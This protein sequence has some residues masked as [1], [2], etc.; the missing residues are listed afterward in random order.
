MDSSE[1]LAKHFFIADHPGDFSLVSSQDQGAQASISRLSRENEQL[2]GALGDVVRRLKELEGEQ[3]R[4]MS[5]DVY[6]FVNSLCRTEGLPLDPGDRECC[7]GKSV[8]AVVI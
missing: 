4:F 3:E 1:K 6:D 5:E 8:A 2:R 7:R